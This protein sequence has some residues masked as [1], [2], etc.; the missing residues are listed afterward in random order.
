MLGAVAVAALTLGTP[1]GA[2]AGQ[3]VRRGAGTERPIGPDP[4]VTLL[5]HGNLTM[6]SNSVLTCDSSDGT[7]CSDTEGSNNGRTMFVKSDPNAPGP[8]ASSAQLVIPAGA[9]VLSARLYWQ[10][11]PTGTSTNGTSGD[12]AK[13]DKV[14]WKVPGSGDYQQVTADTYDYFDQKVGGT[15]PEPLMA[16]GA[17]KDVT[18]EVKAAGAGTYT[19]ADIQACSGRSS[20]QNDGGNN[21]GCW[22]GWSLV[23]AYED[24]AEPLRYLQVWDGYQLLRDPDNLATLTLAG[25][26]TPAGGPAAATM[27]VTVGDGDAPI[28]GDQALVGSEE[29]DLTELL[30]PGPTGIGTDNAFTS[31]I[32]E[33]AAD[34]T[35]ANITTRAPAPVNNYGYDARVLDVTGKI[36][37]DSSQVLLRINGAGDALEPQAVWLALEAREPDLQLT[38]ANEPAGNTSD[39]PPGL[40][41]PGDTITYT[42]TLANKRPDGG[43]SDLDTATGVTLT[44]ELPAGTSYVDGSNP[45]CAAT[46]STV[47]CTSADLA[48]GAS[49]TVSFKAKVAADTAPGTKLDDT[50][51]VAFEG[52]QTGREQKRT[53]N[54]VRNT[55]SSKPGYVIKKTA[56]R[57][58]AAPGDKVTY[59]ID[60]TNSGN[61]GLSRL[62]VTDDLSDLLDDATYDDDATATSGTTDYTAPRLSWTGD[63]GVGE[64]ARLT[65]TV[66]VEEPAAG[67]Q[68]MTNTVVGDLPGGNC[69]AGGSDPDCTTT[70]EVVVPPTPTPT[71]T[72]TEPTPT[73]TE[74]TPTPTPTEPTPTPEPSTSTGGPAPTE[75]GAPGPGPD[76]LPDTGSLAGPAAIAATIA[77]VLGGVLAFAARRRN[78]SNHS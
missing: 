17:V 31:R 8:N 32:D 58:S 67:D 23:V 46:G 10:F 5:T 43:T 12:L 69:T 65:Y 14:S 57:T 48:P 54:T 64:S 50:A 20:A 6:A 45:D 1:S 53:S 40:V 21:V 29:G 55:V 30:M 63:L 39:S 78:R 37:A 25:I 76:V 35:G 26:R 18:A 74:P 11:N 9:T 42:F 3:A 22:G 71:P 56:D 2:S 66:T 7:V 33:V 13:G 77:V 41:D 16:A 61:T 36:P 24:P 72:P 47:T 19:V 34:G 73:P 51:T 52:K 70:T 15:P 27:G 60:V 38:K 49:R 4:M 28:A 75:S 62:T 59:R 44:D 68:Q